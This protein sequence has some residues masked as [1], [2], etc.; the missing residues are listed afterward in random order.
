MTLPR[1]FCQKTY[2]KSNVLQKLAINSY[3]DNNIISDFIS[4]SSGGSSNT[5][6]LSESLPKQNIPRDFSQKTFNQSN[7][8]QKLAINSYFNNNIISESNM[9]V[10]IIPISNSNTCSVLC[11]P[12]KSFPPDFYWKNERLQ[13]L[14]LCQIYT[15][16]KNNRCCST[17]NSTCRDCATNTW[18]RTNFAP[19]NSPVFTGNPQAPTAS[20]GD[21]SNTIATTE[22]VQ[23]AIAAGPSTLTQ[24]IFT[25]NNSSIG[26]TPIYP[27]LVATPVSCNIAPFYI[28]F[29][30][31]YSPTSPTN[32]YIFCNIYYQYVLEGSTPGTYTYFNPSTGN[33]EIPVYY[34][35]ALQVTFDGS[36]YTLASYMDMTGSGINGLLTTGLTVQSQTFIPLSFTMSGSKVLVQFAFPYSSI[37]PPTTGSAVQFFAS[38]S[39]EQSGGTSVAST[40]VGINNIATYQLY[41]NGSNF[42]GQFYLSST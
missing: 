11:Q 15:D 19:I 12:P 4:K 18:V 23:A 6:F 28:N 30:N 27:G 42:A 26:N 40:E 32:Y 24:T 14:T 10:D 17:S 1:D 13:K 20:V 35:Y 29:A 39:L 5:S 25:Y 22:F 38:L 9:N 34:K 41:P 33:P 8:L 2:N 37:A 3:L 21:N 36:S 16:Y 7:V 31:T